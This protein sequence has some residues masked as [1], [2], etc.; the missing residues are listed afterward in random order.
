MR[1]EHL[2]AAFSEHGWQVRIV[3]DEAAGEAVSDAPAAAGAAGALRR[4]AASLARLVLPYPDSYARWSARAGRRLR[5]AESPD[6]VYALAWPFSA[7]ALGAA[8]GSRFGAP[9]VVDVG[10]PWPH[11]GLGDVLLE[12]W[13]LRRAQAMVVTTDGAAELYRRRSGLPAD[14][15]VVA[16]NGADELVR[17]EGREANPPRFLAL[18]TLSAPRVDPTPAFRALAELEAEGALEFSFYGECFLDLPP[19]IAAHHRGR[20]PADE[21]RELMG[22]A[23]ALVIVGNRD[24]RQVPSKV[25]EAAESDLP[26]LYVAGRPTDPGA[27]ILAE[28]GH[29]TVADA[30]DLA[31]CREAARRTLARMRAG[32]RPAP[33]RR[34]T[35]AATEERVLAAA[36]LSLRGRRRDRR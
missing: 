33:A 22:A 17:P 30:G 15:V 31:D 34:F 5:H 36:E 20:V 10:D 18:G 24:P 25:Y 6:L 12:R 19:D 2:A 9:L 11:R 23:D 14:R 35:W 7:I 26:V 4:G 28:T 29:A 1:S 8:L 16:P 32:D 21:A 3:A 13:S 27:A